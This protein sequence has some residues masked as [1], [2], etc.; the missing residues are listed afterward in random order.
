MNT[1][2]GAWWEGLRTSL[3]FV[4]AVM[5]VAA[6]VAAATVEID[7]RLLADARTAGLDLAFG[8][9]VEGARG[10]LGAIAGSIIAVTGTVFSITIVALQLASSQFTPRVLRNFTSDR[11]NQVV[12]GV[13]IGTFTYALLVL[14][15][16]RSAADDGEP[17]VPSLAVGVAI[18]LALASVGF[19][20]YF[21]HHTARSIRA[22]VIIDRATRDTL[23][24]VDELFP[25]PVGRPADRPPEAAPAEWPA[26]V[27]AEAAGYL[28]AVDA[29]GLFEVAR[30]RGLT[31]RMEPNVGEFVL[32]GAAL[33]SAWPAGAVDEEVVG[34]V[35]DAFITGPERTLQH[36]VELGLRQ[37]ADIAVKALSPGINDPTTATICV[38]RL[39]EILVALGNRQLPE[40]ARADEDG[41]A[42]LFAPGSTFERAVELS[43]DQ[44]RHY[45][46]GDPTVARHLLGTLERLALL[47]P[48]DRRP[49]LAR[50]VQAILNAARDSIGEPTD[51]RR[52]EQAGA[53]AAARTDHIRVLAS[54]R[55]DDADPAQA[56]GI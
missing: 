10:V 47:I 49:P 41:R 53:Q 44:I 12:L 32:P 13:F 27:A 7:R 11:G 37:L 24:L 43:F 20:I 6:I 30:E 29:D 18:V 15:T 52:V 54:G 31:L 40:R 26:T 19:L 25:E 36:D 28:Q 35:R 3:W 9:G 14:R 22:A 51:L 16:V 2:A 46:T 17:F 5:T 8:G 38:D 42:R 45:G 48:P 55:R 4:P 34:I 56:R 50:Q 39:A 21:I 23:G 33:A 1:K